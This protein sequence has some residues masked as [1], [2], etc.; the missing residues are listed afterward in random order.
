V[1]YHGDVLRGV[2]PG[3]ETMSEIEGEAHIASMDFLYE[4]ECG[5]G[6]GYAEEARVL[7]GGFELEGEANVGVGVA[8]FLK[9]L[10]DATPCD[11][12][13]YLEGVVVSVEGGPYDDFVAVE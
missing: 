5:A 3:H 9:G 2:L 7:V 11:L 12:V 13:G 1:G 8:E 4:E 10:D 6:T